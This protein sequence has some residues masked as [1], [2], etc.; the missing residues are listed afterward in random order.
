MNINEIMEEKMLKFL[1]RYYPITRVKIKTELQKKSC[2]KRG[3][4]IDD[5][6]HMLSDKSSALVI[7]SKLIKILGRVFNYDEKTCKHLLTKFL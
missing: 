6:P 3:I 5:Y 1:F 7:H 4:Y 2:F